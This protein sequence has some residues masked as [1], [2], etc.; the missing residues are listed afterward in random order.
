MV[1]AHA[2]N[3]HQEFQSN[4]K[5]NQTLDYG[6]SEEVFLKLVDFVK[7]PEVEEVYIV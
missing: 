2:L 4:A 5:T 7:F 6:L 3:R 1:I